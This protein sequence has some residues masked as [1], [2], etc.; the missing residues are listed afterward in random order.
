MI[1][2]LRAK[3]NENFTPAKYQRFLSELDRRSGTHVKFRNSE[4]PCFFPRDL[5]DKMV[6]YGKEL[7]E[8]LLSN[9][10]YLKASD[11]AVPPE[12][13]V[14][15]QTPHPIFLQVDFGIDEHLE[16]KLVE[17]Q[18]FPSLYAYQ[19]VLGE[20]YR[21]VYGLDPGLHLTFVPEYEAL[22]KRAVLGDHD[23]ENVILMEI[24]PLQQKTLPDFLLTEKLCGIKTVSITD[25]VKRGNRLYYGD[26]PIRRIYNRAIVD[27]LQ[28]KGIRPAF[29][30]RDDLDVEWAGHPNWYFRISKFS[31]PF[32][33]HVSVPKTWFLNEVP[34]VPEDLDNY[35]L[36]PLYSFAGL[37]VVIGPTREQIDSVKHPEHYILQE[38][39]N[40]APLIETPFGLTKSEVRVMY[41][42]LDELR[43]VTTIIRMGRGKMMGVD[44]NR[45]MEW[46][47]ASAGF[48]V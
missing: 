29:D 39:M 40:F 8:Q 20:I 37:G 35:V 4:T 24:D 3:F 34:A 14:P 45:D 27:E 13:N 11:A 18:G 41:I 2:D 31:L 21:D 6:R 47:G 33:R 16:P 42:W 17:I 1:P 9:P 28:R 44:Q 30:F 48:F 43:A 5:L 36:K 26:T 22:F 23:P 32:F 46:V 15:N 38:R 10:A 25:V 12:Y 19:P 7:T